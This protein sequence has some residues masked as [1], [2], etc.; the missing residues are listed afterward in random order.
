M[1][2]GVN[3]ISLVKIKEI[4][5]KLFILNRQMTKHLLAPTP[6]RARCTMYG[7]RCTPVL[8]TE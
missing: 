5:W 8:V 7:V 2:S 4:F 3:Y 6:I 1:N